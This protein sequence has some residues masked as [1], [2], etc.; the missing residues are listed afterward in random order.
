LKKKKI[1]QVFIFNNP[2]EFNYT[3]NKLQKSFC[4]TNLI[5]LLKLFFKVEKKKKKS[6]ILSPLSQSRFKKKNK[7]EKTALAQFFK[8]AVIHSGLTFFF[9]VVTLLV[10]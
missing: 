9:Q 4:I 8:N 10:P 2:L 6:Y 7:I 3:V 5:F 1:S